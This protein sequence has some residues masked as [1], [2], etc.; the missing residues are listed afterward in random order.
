MRLSSLILAA[1]VLAA[2]AAAQQRRG[3]PAISPQGRQVVPTP[4]EPRTGRDSTVQAVSL[5]GRRV[6]EV[7][8]G[9]EMLLRGRVEA[10]GVMIERAES[11]AN[12]CLAMAR[13][14]EVSRGMLCRGCLAAAQQR[15]VARYGE[16]LPGVARAG[17]ACASRLGRLRGSGPPTPAVARALRAE[18]MPLNNRLVTALRAYEQRLRAVREEMGWARQGA[19]PTGSR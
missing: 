12:R 7:R 16:Q 18:A 17:R 15:A 1:T 6:A 11:M 9:L 14:A 19:V 10:D 8:T 13:Q 3:P 4:P 2:P 5:L